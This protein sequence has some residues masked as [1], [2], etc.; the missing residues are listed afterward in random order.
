M[1]LT[2]KVEEIRNNLKKEK[3]FTENP[4]DLA[5]LPIPPFIGKGEI[6]LIVLGQDPTIK[7]A[8]SR[9]KITST[10]NLDKNNA[11]K[12][13]INGIVSQMGMNIENVYATNIFKYFYTYPPATTMNVLKVHLLPN[14]NILVDELSHFP[15]IPIITLGEPVL[16]LVTNNK[17][18]VREFWGYDLKTKKTN[19]SFSYCSAKSNLLERDFFPFPH[20]RSISKEFYKTNLLNYI[21]FVNLNKNNNVI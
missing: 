4:I 19:R 1:E 21:E 17:T 10:L 9:G 15:G 5:L 3:D 13:Y 20:Q 16:Q 8:V 11:L 12:T 6:K 2:K 18:K 7:N 14:L